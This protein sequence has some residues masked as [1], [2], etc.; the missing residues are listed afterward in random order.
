[1]ISAPIAVRLTLK[2]KLYAYSGRLLSRVC[3]NA[4]P[5]AKMMQLQARL[6]RVVGPDGAVALL[7]R[8]QSVCGP[9]PAGSAPYMRA[10]QQLVG[11]LL[12]DSLAECLLDSNA[13]VRHGPVAPSRRR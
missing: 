7:A 1:M 4:V 3:A 8:A 5:H 13:N 12:G 2:E 9:E 10:L 6:S 11:N